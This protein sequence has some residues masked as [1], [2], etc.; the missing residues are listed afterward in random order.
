MQPKTYLV[1]GSLEQ[2]RGHDDMVTCFQLFR[3]ALTSP[4]I[5]TYDELY[6][7]AKC[8]VE[9]ISTARQDAVADPIIPEIDDDMP[10]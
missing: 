8:I 3:A 5:L 10:F 1:A 4:E 2:M 6:E 9:T 7:R